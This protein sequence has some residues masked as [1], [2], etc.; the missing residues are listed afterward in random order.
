MIEEAK[1]AGITRCPIRDVEAQAAKC[2]VDFKM[3]T[4]E[5]ARAAA[6]ALVRAGDGGN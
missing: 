6:E 3:A 1:A 2:P 5:E 4:P